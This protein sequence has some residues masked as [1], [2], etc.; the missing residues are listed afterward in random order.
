MSDQARVREWPE[1]ATTILIGPSGQTAEC[2]RFAGCDGIPVEYPGQ[3]GRE[4][5]EGWTHRTM[6]Q[7]VVDSHAGP[8]DVVGVAM[9]GDIVANLLVHHAERIRSAVIICSDAAAHPE[10]PEQTAKRMAEVRRRAE[11]VLK[12]GMETVVEY[13]LA[14]W[15][16]PYAL[17]ADLPGVR[18][19]RE[20]LLKT[21]PA[22]WYDSAMAHVKSERIS[23]AALKSVTQPVTIAG[24]MHAHG[25]ALRNAEQV[26]A[27][28]AKSR[29]EVLPASRMMHLEHPEFIGAILDR[30]RVWAPTAAR[31]EAPIGAC[32]WLN[33]ADGP[34]GSVSGSAA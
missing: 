20:T 24:G 28:I 9:G 34:F 30:H 10:T 25:A 5:R 19:A 8:L 15:F 18:Y 7:E 21:D 13:T 2:W 11:I 14:R 22:V 32:V 6:A 27:A 1:R 12:D 17:R 33:L 26:H 23:L 29:Y 16:S 4:R 31:L 3:G